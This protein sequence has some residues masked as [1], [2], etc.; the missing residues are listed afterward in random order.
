MSRG[1]LPRTKATLFTGALAASLLGGAVAFAPS[2]SAASYPT[3]NGVKTVTLD[4]GATTIKQPYYKATGSRNCILKYGNTSSAVEEL[5]FNLWQC[6]NHGTGLDGIFGPKTR[7]AVENV[8]A[9]AKIT[10]DG[11]YG[12]NTRKAMKWYYYKNGDPGRN[13]IKANV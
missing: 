10:K 6:H 12:P 5:Q 9:A 2:A 8:Q 3:C 7:T 1:R 4:A 11:I 13:C